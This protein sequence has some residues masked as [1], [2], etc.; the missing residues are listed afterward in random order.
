[1]SYTCFIL[2]NELKQLFQD[3]LIDCGPS[4]S[5]YLEIGRQAD[6]GK[7]AQ[8]VSLCRGQLRKRG[9]SLYANKNKYQLHTHE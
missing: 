9:C 6:D 7:M 5:Q 8:F 1:M 3:G 4:L 2:I